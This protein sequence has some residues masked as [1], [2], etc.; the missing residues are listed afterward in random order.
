MSTWQP[1]HA[2][3]HT[4]V[5]DLRIWHDFHS[6]QLDNRRDVLVW[7]PPEYVDSSR[8]YPV[9][10]MHDA[11]NLFDRTGSYSGEWEVDE[12]LTALAQEGLDAI[13]VGL[14]NMREMRGV[15]YCPY[16]F[17][18]YEGA[19]AEGRGD[20]YIRFIIETVKPQIDRDFRTLPEAETTGIAGSSMGGLISLYGF[21]AYPEVFGLCG[22]FSPAYWFGENGLLATV[23][24]RSTGHGRVYLDVGTKEGET[25]HGWLNIFGEEADNTYRDGVR[26]LRD[27]LLSRGYTLEQ[28]LMYVEDEGAPHRESAWAARLPAALRFLLAQTR[29]TTA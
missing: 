18:T 19:Q 16:P 24:Q 2:E 22:S 3:Q 13:V 14:P 28:N 21:L 12:T 4:V 6:P 10:Y 1:Y 17:R 26:D 7:L 25:L 29:E 11:Q 27:A 23:Q 8:R 9:L 5:G 20:D 15:E